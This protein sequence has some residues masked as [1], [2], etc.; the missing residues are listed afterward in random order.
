MR[1][2]DLV[3]VG[4]G[5][6]GLGASIA[7]AR[8]GA[9]V[10]IVDEN[11]RP[12]GQLFKQIHK[13]FGSQEHG[14]GTRGL[15]LGQ[16]LLDQAREAGVEVM[17]DTV[18]WGVYDGDTLALR[19]GR[20]VS[21][22]K[23]RRILF[24]TGASE[25]A[26]PFPGWTLPGVVRA[27]AAQTMMNI[28]RI[29]PGRRA[30]VVGAGNVGLIVAYQLRQAGAEVAAVVEAT[31]SIGG[32]GVHAAKLARW[33]VPILTRHTIIEAGGSERVQWATVAAVNDLFQP[34]PGTQVR[35]EVDLICMAVGLTPL[36]ELCRLSGCRLVHHPALGGWV[37]IHDSD[38][39][40]TQPNIFAAGDVSGIG[41]ASIALDEGRI[42]GLAAAGDLGFIDGP[43]LGEAQREVRER[44][45][46]MRSGP[47]SVKVAR[48]K[49]E[50]LGLP[51]GGLEEAA[52][53][54][55][56]AH[57]RR[58]GWLCGTEVDA[59]PGVP[60]A[61][62]VGSR[63][64]AVVECA[65]RIPCNPCETVCPKGAITVGTPITNLPRLDPSRC[66]GCGLCVAV[67]P[68]QAVFL[69]DGSRPG[70]EGAVV[71]PYENLPLPSVGQEVAGL[72]RSG[73]A[74]CRGRVVKVRKAYAFDRTVTVEIA[75]PKEAV[76]AVRGFRT[77]EGGEPR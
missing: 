14:A 51:D 77:E 71:L 9:K 75:V 21:R 68:G 18:A 61:T 27:G 25:R 15:R 42:A 73:R 60:E 3:C 55:Q 23:A 44:I 58:L 2:A 10:L 65:E 46:A 70:E 41:E 66:T 47:L 67:C 31:G 20:D 64:V 30:L 16:H 34:V 59:L 49:A 40:T 12:G 74:V 33:G 57:L 76:M 1:E 22:L 32:Y 62:A 56:P 8:A 38:M 6:A 24:A 13:F 52:D 19:Q 26:L 5:P 48:A 37:P 29:R 4:A 53:S 54:N 7:A 69:V 17:L 72:D 39:R 36:T 43:A 11:A 45:Q 63:R 50:L 28:H 35:F